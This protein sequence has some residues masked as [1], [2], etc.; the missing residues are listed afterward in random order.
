MAHL[1]VEGRPSGPG[2]TYF[3][4][5]GSVTPGFFR[6]AGVRVLRGRG[7]E[8]TDYQPGALA[9]V[10]V[11]ESFAERLFPDADPVGRR[12]AMGGNGTNWRTVV[13]I[14]EDVRDI[15]LEESPQPLFFMPETGGW[16]WMTILVRTSADPESLVGAVRREIWGLDPTIAVPTVEPLS[17][18]KRR[19]LAGPRFN[20]LL[21]G[22]F[23]AVAMVLAVL[24]IYGIMSHTVV[25]RT[26]EIGI[27]IALGAQPAWVRPIQW[28]LS[29]TSEVGV[30]LL[31]SLG[32]SRYHPPNLNR[33]VPCPTPLRF[34]PARS[35]S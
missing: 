1:P 27:R 30:V 9:V 5:W 17:A 19:A 8:P 23:E 22:A 33:R 2:E 12:V 26:R 11:T 35:T 4:R 3:A 20:L 16:P 6:A 21:M 32:E 13:G 31:D 24:A 28:S 14:V 25:Q 10:V 34:S 18:S 7:L 29:G 15:G